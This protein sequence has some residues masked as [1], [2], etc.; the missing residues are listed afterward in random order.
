MG[1]VFPGVFQLERVL[2]GWV[3]MAEVVLGMSFPGGFLH[4]HAHR[5]TEQAYKWEKRDISTLVLP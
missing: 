3:R 5:T 1:R 2:S 4:G